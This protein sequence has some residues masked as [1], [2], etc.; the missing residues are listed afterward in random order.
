[1]ANNSLIGIILS[2]WS[3]LESRTSLSNF[4]DPIPLN[5]EE[6]PVKWIPD[7]QN[8]WRVVYID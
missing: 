8:S 3:Q 7:G 1:M 5:S 6:K 2:L 4:P